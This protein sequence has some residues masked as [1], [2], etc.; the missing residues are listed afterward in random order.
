MCVFA[1]YMECSQWIGILANLLLNDRSLML[2]A[3]ILLWQNLKVIIGKYTH[4]YKWYKYIFKNWMTTC[5]LSCDMNAFFWRL[6][7]YHEARQRRYILYIG[8]TT[9]R[10]VTRYKHVSM[11]QWF[12]TKS[13]KHA[14]HLNSNYLKYKYMCK[15]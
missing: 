2:C 15:I 11:S 10:K 4:N 1:L 8:T 7:I 12:I 9:L 3:L 6:T 5:L 13:V 14:S